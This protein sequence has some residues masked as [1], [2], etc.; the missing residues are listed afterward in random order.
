M[1]VNT[2]ND[3]FKER[4]RTLRH[5]STIENDRNGSLIRSNSNYRLSPASQKSIDY[6][7]LDEDGFE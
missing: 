6:D 4:S 5:R 3:S 7:D 2:I 1:V